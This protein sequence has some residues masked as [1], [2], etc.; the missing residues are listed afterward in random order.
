MP[1]VLSKSCLA[2]N[3]PW[4]F[5]W[6]HKLQHQTLLVSNYLDYSHKLP[7]L[8]T[9]ACTCLPKDLPGFALLQ[10]QLK[11]FPQGPHGYTPF[12]QHYHSLPYLRLDTR[13]LM[14][15]VSYY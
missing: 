14:L 11:H 10:P 1:S 15:I 2:P 3:Q 12:V 13:E 5:M 7:S 4:N 9:V 8:I 6:F